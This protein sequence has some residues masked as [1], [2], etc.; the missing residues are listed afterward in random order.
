MKHLIIAA[1]MLTAF[2]GCKKEPAP[3]PDCETYN[4]GFF[5]LTNS[6]NKLVVWQLAGTQYTNQNLYATDSKT[7]NLPVGNYHFAAY[8]PQG[9]SWELYFQVEQCKTDP[10][11]ITN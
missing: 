10:V 7:F 9:G 3:V 6:T 2:A 11:S 8:S 5:K 4:Y 1:T